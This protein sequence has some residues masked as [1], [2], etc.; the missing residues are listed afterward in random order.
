MKYFNFNYFLNLRVCQEG[1]MQ[2][3]MG[4]AVKQGNLG[5]QLQLFSQ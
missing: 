5:Q 2:L 3:V 1:A 4:E